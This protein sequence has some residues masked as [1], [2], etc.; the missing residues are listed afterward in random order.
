MTWHH[1]Q[2]QPEVHNISHY[3]QRRTEPLPQVTCTKNFMNVGHLVFKIQERKNIQPHRQRDGHADRNTSQP[4]QP[5]SFRFPFRRRFGCTKRN[6]FAQ[7][8]GPDVVSSA[9]GLAGAHE[10]RASFVEGLA[11]V[12]TLETGGVPLEVGR[13]A[14]QVLVADPT[15][16]ARTRRHRCRD[17]PGPRRRSLMFHP[18]LKSRPSMFYSLGEPF[19]YTNS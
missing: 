1:P 6:S 4:S 3:C 8:D 5:K 14:Q 2:N 12:D 9:V 13:H 7:A 11:A 15:L 16:A 17:L 18:A 19:L 10:A